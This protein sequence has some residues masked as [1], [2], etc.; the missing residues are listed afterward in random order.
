M[1]AGN[2][3]KELNSLSLIQVLIRN[4]L[5]TRM[6]RRYADNKPRNFFHRSMWL[7]K[8]LAF[9]CSWQV[10][11]KG[12][13]LSCDLAVPLKGLDQSLASTDWNSRLVMTK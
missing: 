12:Q 2:F 11:I 1:R 10:K 9:L 3:I 6:G 7:G 8:W 5:F 4:V 13:I